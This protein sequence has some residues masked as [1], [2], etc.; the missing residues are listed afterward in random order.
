MT[1]LMGERIP[2]VETDYWTL[3]TEVNVEGFTFMHADVYKWS[4][5]RYKDILVDFYEWLST[6][7]VKE[8]TVYF[9]VPKEE[10][11]IQ[12]FGEMLGFGHFIEYQDLVVYMLEIE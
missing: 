11:K 6:A 9:A 7:Q 5:D 12:K 4:V 1:P 8:N 10:T 3:S 2:V